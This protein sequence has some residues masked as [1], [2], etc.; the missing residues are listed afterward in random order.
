[1]N[2]V[3]R[4][5]SCF[6]G[7]CVC[8]QAIF[9]TFSEQLGLDRQ[10][11][12]KIADAFGAGMGGLAETCG[13]VTGAFMVIGLKYG[14][15]EPDDDRAKEKT[16]ELV[17]KFVTEFKARRQT[18]VCK[19]LLGYDISTA[20]GMQSAEEKGIFGDRC[21]KIVRDAAEILEQLV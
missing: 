20:A 5:V 8:S 6:A 1:M 14:R 17:K 10:I 4:A 16:R 21:P 2:N 19:E 13:A 11:A 12:M 7:G 3:D 15:G 18:I 9:A